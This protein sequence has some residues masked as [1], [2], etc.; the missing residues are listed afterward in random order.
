MDRYVAIIT[1]Q[2]SC[3]LDYTL[4]SSLK[5]PCVCSSLLIYLRNQTLNHITLTVHPHLSELLGTLFSSKLFG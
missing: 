4:I 1:M 3:Y 5:K 2:N